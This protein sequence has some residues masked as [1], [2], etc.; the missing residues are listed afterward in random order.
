[1]DIDEVIISA[2]YHSKLELKLNTEHE[3]WVNS[4]YMCSPQPQHPSCLKSATHLLYQMLS[5]FPAVFSSCL[6]LVF[7]LQFK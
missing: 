5:F 2:V 1:M 3:I 7:F 4:V 6:L